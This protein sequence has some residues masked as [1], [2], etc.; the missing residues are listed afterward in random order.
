VLSLSAFL[1][2]YNEADT[3]EEVAREL[4]GVLRDLGRPYELV[5]VDDG[6]TDGTSAIADRLVR[7]LEQASVIHHGKNCGL[8]DTYLTAFGR[9]RM[10]LLAFFYGDGQIPPSLLYTF[11]AAFDGGADM[12]LGYLPRRKDPLIGILLSQIERLILN[13][14]FGK[15]PKVQGFIMFRRNLLQDFPLKLAGGRAWTVLWELMI[16]AYKGGRKIVSIPT[17]I[18]QRTSG[19]SKVNNL[20]TAWANFRRTM[21]LYWHVRRS[22]KS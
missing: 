3:L 4:D 14:M 9:A 12:A 13:S 18:R 16:R 11:L 15:L 22:I 21:Q 5:I 10:D 7:E 8:G 6:S 1:F 19:A 17:V 20:P 2:A